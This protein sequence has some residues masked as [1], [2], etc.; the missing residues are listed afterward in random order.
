MLNSKSLY[1]YDF[2]TL[3]YMIIA[4]MKDILIKEVLVK[5]T[6]IMVFCRNSYKGTLYM[7]ISSTPSGGGGGAIERHFNKMVKFVVTKFL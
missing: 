1:I 3:L 6:Q 2:G 4:V 7:L 5:K